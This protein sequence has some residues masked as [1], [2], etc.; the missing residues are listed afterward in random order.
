MA[1]APAQ[2]NESLPDGLKVFSIQI[3]AHGQGSPAEAVELARSLRIHLWGAKNAR[4]G[5]LKTAQAI[6]DREQVPVTFF[7]ANEEYGTWV[8]FPGFGTYSHTSD[9][10]APAGVDIGPSLA[11]AGVVTGRSTASGA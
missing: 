3:E 10:I 6:A 9:I 11:D 2:K 8:D 1:V 4:P 7:V 5:W